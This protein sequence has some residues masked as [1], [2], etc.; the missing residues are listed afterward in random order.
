MKFLV[1]LSDAYGSIG[2][3]GLYNRHLLTAL[4]NYPGC[5]EVVALPLIMPHKP[6]SM[7]DKLNYVTGALGGK[8][9]Y[10]KE[11]I[12]SIVKYRY[13][14][15]IIC[16]HINL[17]P[18]AF[19]AKSFIKSPILL[20][21]YGIDAWQPTK[22]VLA[23]KLAE[24]IDA[25]ISISDITKDRFLK[26]SRV[27]KEKGHLLPNPID[28]DRY[29]PGSKNPELLKR[30]GL[31]NK[32]VLMT[33]GR[34][35][36]LERY[37]GFDEVLEVLPEISVDTPDIAY[38]IVGEGEDKKRL[39]EKAKIL[40]V[41][42]RVVFTGF[43]AEDE[44]IEHFRLADVYVM[45]SYGEGFGFVFLEALACGIP[46]IGSTLDGSQ[47]ALKGGELGDLVD[48]RDPHALKKSIL[49][50]LKIVDRVVP[51][52]IN[53]FSSYN[54]DQRLYKIIESQISNQ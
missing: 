25:F 15:L 32:K 29:G 54:Y 6:E 5:S 47:E 50:A 37:K 52:G 45:P 49:R 23:N 28:L 34:L 39:E 35:N 31:E 26:W 1:I 22:S 10:I 11:L 2:G 9:N 3:I 36:P 43:I 19:I 46:T 20:E 41:G 51:D 53:Y 40:G 38:L 18:V 8:C 27:N 14:D 42:D 17:L 33:F 21:I 4:C 16:A 30:Y 48:P 7:P 44:K 12:K 24:K 13:F